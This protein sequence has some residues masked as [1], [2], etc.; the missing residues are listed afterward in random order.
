VLAC[1]R[2]ALLGLVSAELRSEEAGLDARFLRWAYGLTPA[3]NLLNRL[4]IE[5]ALVP[6][7]TKKRPSADAAD[8]LH[9]SE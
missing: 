3:S 5:L 8:D 6:P 7:I 1:E 9:L 4:V 2:R